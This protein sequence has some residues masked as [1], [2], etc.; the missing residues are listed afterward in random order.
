MLP[1][2]TTV[3]SK[4]EPLFESFP[5]FKS[6]QS[7]GT[8]P[9]SQIIH[10]INE[11]KFKEQYSGYWQTPDD[12]KLAYRNS[13]LPCI[14]VGGQSDPKTKIAS[15][16]QYYNNSVAFKLTGIRGK[17]LESLTNDELTYGLIHTLNKDE[18]V[19]LVC[20]NMADP[21]DQ[22][23]R[24]RYAEELKHFLQERH[25]LLTEAIKPLS[26]TS[27][28]WPDE[29]QHHVNP[30]ARQWGTTSSF[31]HV[32]ILPASESSSDTLTLKDKMDQALIQEVENEMD[33][34]LVPNQ[35]LPASAILNQVSSSEKPPISSTD[36]LARSLAAEQRIKS[37][38]TKPIVFRPPLISRAEVGIIKRNTVNIIQGSYGSHKSR[39]AELFAALM[40]SIDQSNDPQFLGFKRAALERFCVC[41]MD[42]ERNMDEEM[43]AAIQSINRNAGYPLEDIPEHFRFTSIKGEKRKDR[44]EAVKVFICYLR[45]QSDLHLFCLIDVVTDAIG[46]FNNP[47]DAMELFD[48]L[49][50]LC[51]DFNATFL[52]VIHQNPGTEKARGHAGTEAMNK[53]VTALQI[54]IEKDARG[55]DTEMIKLRYLKLRHSKKPE[56]LYL[57]FYQEFNSLRLADLE[58]L[59]NHLNNRKQIALIE[60]MT[61]QLEMLLSEGPMTKGEIVE[62]LMKYFDA[63]NKT[64]RN[65]LGSIA[66]EEYRMYD[67][68]GRPVF[69]DSYKDG[70]N[71]YYRLQLF[72]LEE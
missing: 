23:Q 27:F 68:E 39:L 16:L 38:A 31:V 69:L 30:A 53:A 45:T 56:S 7:D 20:T 60:D 50:N 14:R 18:F 59:D 17:P 48:F 54:G 24:D 62:N 1:E 8:I 33:Q 52:L 10:L 3:F 41:Y 11:G 29:K 44:L 67:S 28:C 36:S 49:G 34:L 40:L 2:D 57:Q 66:K 6:S 65:R 12:Q 43:P 71:E 64:I 51:D 4:Q 37:T 21:S 42:T 26:P 32:N 19:L 72:K 70:K 61:E 13:F 9:L 55:N 47:E 25:G 58:T 35:P 63:S 22:L 46:N 5:S 15:L